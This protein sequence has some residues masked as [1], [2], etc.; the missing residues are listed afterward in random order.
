MNEEESGDE[1]LNTGSDSRERMRKSA[2]EQGGKSKV[3]MTGKGDTDLSVH[4]TQWPFHQVSSVL[5][6][7]T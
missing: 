2:V 3:E 1:V 4:L 5:H 6:Q 7:F